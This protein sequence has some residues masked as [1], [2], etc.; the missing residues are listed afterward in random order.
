MNY[1]KI[2]ASSH[3]TELDQGEELADNQ[4][5]EIEYLENAAV[6]ICKIL[7]Q[8]EKDVPSVARLHNLNE[9]IDNILCTSD[10]ASDYISDPEYPDREPS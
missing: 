4:V 5:E 2:D 10:E 1:D 9:V 3:D 6:K 7:N 8:L